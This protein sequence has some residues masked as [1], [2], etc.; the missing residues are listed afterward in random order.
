MKVFII[1][2]PKAATTSITDFLKQYKL[3]TMHWIGG[4]VDIINMEKSIKPFIDISRKY[5][6]LSDAPYNVLFQELDQEY[7]DAKFIYIDREIE[8]WA[9]SHIEHNKLYNPQKK[10][11][12][13]AV[14]YLE[15]E[16]FKELATVQD[17]DNL[18]KKYKYH[19]ERVLEYFKDRENLLFLPLDFVDKEQRICKFLGLEYNEN[20][21][22][23]RSNVNRSY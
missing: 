8:S 15:I 20:I 2:M 22:F 16:F 13:N 5:D 1:S 23:N 6:V 17:Y 18:I 9:I 7:E 19:Q 14:E 10:L 4:H 3:N 21:K 12:N 11:K